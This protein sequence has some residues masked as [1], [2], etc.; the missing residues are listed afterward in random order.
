MIGAMTFIM[1][2]DLYK[3]NIINFFGLVYPLSKLESL[4]GAKFGFRTIVS[5]SVAGNV[6]WD[7]LI[8]NRILDPGRDRWWNWRRVICRDKMRKNRSVG[9]TVSCL[10]SPAPPINIF[11]KMR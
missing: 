9:F 6:D 7:H 4:T 11:K 10:K 2:D 8:S 1:D 3:C 5:N